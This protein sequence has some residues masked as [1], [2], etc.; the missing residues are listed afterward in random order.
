MVDT[1]SK[2]KLEDLRLQPPLQE[3][4]N[5]QTQDVIELHLTLIQHTDS[6][7]TPQQ[8]VTWIQKSHLNFQINPTSG[9]RW[10]Q[11]C[12]IDEEFVT[13]QKSD[14]WSFN[15]RQILSRRYFDSLKYLRTDAWGP[16][17]PESAALWQLCEFWPGWTWPSTPHACSSAHT[18]LKT[19]VK[20][21]PASTTHSFL[22]DTLMKTYQWA[23]TPGRDGISR[24][25]GG[26]WHKSCCKPN[27]WQRAWRL[28]WACNKFHVNTFQKVTQQ[29]INRT[30]NWY[31][32]S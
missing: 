30:Q 23:S 7:Q 4:F 16:S 15:H 27:S 22:A 11:I 28:I 18:R 8:G 32:L 3:I 31:I 20:L 12:L 21:S 13:S 1:L 10:C 2:A 9:K 19:G 29:F 24:R 26:G 17:H 5:L 25:A 14:N 6:H